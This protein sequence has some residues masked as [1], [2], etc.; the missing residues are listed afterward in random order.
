MFDSLLLYIFKILFINFN[1]I[2]D[3]TKYKIARHIQRLIRKLIEYKNLLKK[4]LF[5]S[6]LTCK[7]PMETE[8]Q[9][10]K[11][12]KNYKTA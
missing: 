5:F 3:K 2:I 4:N 6:L 1:I 12:K 9:E 7:L 8:L 10:E 11:E